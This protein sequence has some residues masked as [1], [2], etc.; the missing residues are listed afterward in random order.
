M[1]YL[2]GVPRTV[3]RDCSYRR[4]DTIN[5]NHKLPD[6]TTN[7]PTTELTFYNLPLFSSFLSVSKNGV[8][9]TSFQNPNQLT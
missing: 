8:S 7:Y 2:T 1:H 5:V 6:W 9:K 3:G 4:W